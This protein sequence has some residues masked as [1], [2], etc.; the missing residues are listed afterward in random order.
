MRGGDSD[1]KES[2]G[3]LGEKV[4]EPYGTGGSGIGPS[5]REEERKG[6]GVDLDRYGV[7]FSATIS[8]PKTTVPADR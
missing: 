5:E 1:D 8:I 4:S 7:K 2:Y 6:D 3:T